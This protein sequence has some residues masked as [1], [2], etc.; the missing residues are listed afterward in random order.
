MAEVLI[1]SAPIGPR[2]APE[3]A[4]ALARAQGEFPPIR[5]NRTA[6]V[7]TR[8]GGT[9]RFGFADL[10]TVIAAVR[11]ALA[12]HEL[13]LTQNPNVRI[14]DGATFVGVETVLAHS[15]GAS[16]STVLELS[17]GDSTPQAIG[18][19]LTFARRYSI[20]ALLGIAAEDDDDAEAARGAPQGPRSS[21]DRRPSSPPQDEAPKASESQVKLVWA[22]ARERA[23][24]FV[25]EGIRRLRS[26]SRRRSCGR[27]FRRAWNR[28]RTSRLAKWTA[29]SSGSRRS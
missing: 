29:S 22:R 12:R 10:A 9:Y 20:L 17:V 25:A 21:R 6:D 27:R 26:S 28:R 15:S 14:V 23:Q 8:S 3:L 18:S 2:I 7:Q 16:I 19:G 4:A 13:A 11:P 1:E 24:V 5:K